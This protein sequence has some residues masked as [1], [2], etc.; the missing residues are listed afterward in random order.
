MKNILHDPV[1]GMDLPA[2][3]VFMSEFV[4]G[5]TYG[6]CSAECLNAFIGNESKYT[7]AKPA[8]QEPFAGGSHE[9]L[10]R[11]P[12]CGNTVDEKTAL[13]VEQNGK[14]FYFCSANCK[15]VFERV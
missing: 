11:D 5:V 14:R 12:V 13:S 15:Q 1:C 9:H 3:Q 2:N 6:F 4:G 8:N 10:T 7:S